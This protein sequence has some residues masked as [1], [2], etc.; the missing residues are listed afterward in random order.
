MSITNGESYDVQWFKDDETDR[1]E[2]SHWNMWTYYS[3]VG[4]PQY[5]AVV[6]ADYAVS[7]SNINKYDLLT[8]VNIFQSWS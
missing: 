7:R 6:A 3:E 1:V 4:L 8:V 2:D 5:E